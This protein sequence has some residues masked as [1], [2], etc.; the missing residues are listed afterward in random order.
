MEFSINL[1]EIKQKMD[2]MK[3]NYNNFGLFFDSLLSDLD[4]K[5]T[6]IS[7]ILLTGNLDTGFQ[8]MFQCER[9]G[10]NCTSDCKAFNIIKQYH[11]PLCNSKPNLDQDLEYRIDYLIQN[12]F[13]YLSNLNTYFIDGRYPKFIIHK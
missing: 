13:Y 6:I 8:W 9:H 12:M 3:G 4:Q 7:I 11:S 2:N 5:T 1:N 10:Y